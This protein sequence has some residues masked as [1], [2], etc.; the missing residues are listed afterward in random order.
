MLPFA[1]G[2]FDAVEGKQN[3]H[4]LDM[5]TAVQEIARL[6]CAPAVAPSLSGR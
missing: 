2:A 3:L 6:C 5:Q 4:H 1:D